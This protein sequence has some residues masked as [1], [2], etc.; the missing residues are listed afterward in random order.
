MT[1]II[2]IFIFILLFAGMVLGFYTG[3][4][5]G[6]KHTK[7]VQKDRLQDLCSN[8]GLHEYGDLFIAI[9]RENETAIPVYIDSNKNIIEKS[10]TSEDPKLYYKDIKY[11]YWLG[12]EKNE[13]DRNSINSIEHNHTD[14]SSSSSISNMV[15]G[16]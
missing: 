8:L 1:N 14:R 4:E 9:S 6:V 15:Y 5:A 3:Y 2:I 7:A 12:G 11:Y 16:I 13:R 10:T